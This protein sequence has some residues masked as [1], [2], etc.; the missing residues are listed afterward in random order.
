MNNLFKNCPP[1]NELVNY[2][3][4]NLPIEQANLFETHF[5]DCNVCEETIRGLSANDTLSQLVSA[6]VS[7]AKETILPDRNFIDGLVKQIQNS[8]VA[9]DSIDPALYQRAAEVLR[10][11]TPTSDVEALGELGNYKIEKLVGAGSTGV[12]FCATDTQLNRKVALKVLRPSLG[13]SARQRFVSEAQAAASIEHANVVT[14]YQVD[15]V[16]ELVFIAMQWIDGETLEDRLNKVTF[17]TEPQLKSIAQQIASGLHAAHQKNLIHRDIKPANIWLSQDDDQV[18]ILDFGLARIADDDPHLTSTGMLAGTPNFMSPEQSK[19]LELDG[20]SDLFSLGCLMYRS[21]TGKLPFG[22]NGILATLQ[23]IQHHHPT[24]PHQLNPAISK[25][26]ADL[27]MCLL[28]KQ[29][30]NRPE[31]AEQLEN[32]CLLYTS[33]SP[34]DRTRS[35]MPSSA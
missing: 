5:E 24:P 7:E 34:R 6:A 17:V 4:G 29:P 19:G 26:F 3:L 11:I 28:D 30:A 9:D 25:D 31:S 23:S 20:R 35:R 1:K 12:V 13:S 10:L 15:N 33:P 16:D 32:A 21:A 8:T 22:A 14:I 2:L 27:T 18:K